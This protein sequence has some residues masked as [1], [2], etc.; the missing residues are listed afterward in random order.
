MLTPPTT[1]PIVASALSGATWHTD[2]RTNVTAASDGSVVQVAFDSVFGTFI[3]QTLPDG[4]Y[5]SYSNLRAASVAVG[6]RISAG[7]VIGTSTL[8]LHVSISDS[9]TGYRGDGNLSDPADYFAVP[10]VTE[11]GDVPDPAAAIAEVT[12]EAPKTLS[13]GPTTATLSGT[14]FTVTPATS[15][16]A[17][18]GAAWFAP[19]APEESSAPALPPVHPVDQIVADA[20]ATPRSAAAPTSHRQKGALLLKSP[21]FT[22][23]FWNDTLT[24]AFNTFLQVSLASIGTGAV[25]LLAIDYKSTLSLAAGATLVSLVTSLIRGTSTPGSTTAAAAT[26]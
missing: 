16:S 9:V 22:L 21:L 20:V 18:F 6:E 1:A 2:D 25:H 23:L 12:V 7:D 24:R 11:T 3:V 10:P 8:I 15:T 5:L 26:A 19:T 13:F 4:K 17:A 14:G